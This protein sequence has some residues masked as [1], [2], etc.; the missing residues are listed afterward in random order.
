M[1]LSR[2]WY[3]VL[4]LVLGMA[5]YIVF[6]AVGQYNRRNGVAMTEE[7]ASDSQTVGWALQI[8]SRKRLDALLV[9]AVDKGV[10]DA[11]QGA[12]GKDAIPGKVK[13]DGRRALIAVLEK[14]AADFRP[15]ALF[16][17][18]HEGR[19]VS[20][21]G[22]DAANALPDFELGGYPVVFDAIHGYLR[23]DTWVLGG[24][25][26][27]VAARP[28]EFDA[29]Q[30]PLG[31]IVA[32]RLVDK[33]FTQDLS[34][35]TRANIAFYAGGQRVVSASLEGFDENQLALVDKDLPNLASDKAYGEGRSEVRF[36]SPDVGI[37]YARLF[38]DAW[39]LGG[40]FAVARDRI[41]IDG[42]QGF[43]NGADDKDKQSVNFVFIAAVVLGGILGGLLFS[44]LEHSL[45]L[46]EM[47]QQSLRL[48]KGEID[49]FQLP[50]FRGTY[51]A[52]AQ[53]VNLGIERVL[54]KGGSAL[55]KP[56]DLESILGPVP[57]QPA[58]SAFSFSAADSPPQPPPPPPRPLPSAPGFND[59]PGPAPHVPAAG[60]AG[61]VAAAAGLGG[62][63][64]GAVARPP[65]PKP[66]P[67]AHA[68]PASPVQGAPPATPGTPPTGPAA[69]GS[70]IPALP[71]IRRPVGSEP[72]VVLGQVGSGPLGGSSQAGPAGLAGSSPGGSG[73]LGGLPQAG[74]AGQQKQ[75]GFPPPP[76]A[77]PLKRT[78]SPTMVG[79]GE[80]PGA[81]SSPLSP[82]TSPH[83]FTPQ[84]PAVGSP[85]APGGG[86][87]AASPPAPSRPQVNAPPPGTTKVATPSPALPRPMQESGDQED[88]EATVVAPAPS[89][90]LAQTAGAAQAA[91]AKAPNETAEWMTVYDDFVRTKKQCGEPTEGL[92]FEKFQ[93]TLRKN[94]DALMQRHSCKRVRFSV[95]VK[96]GRASLKAT[97]LRD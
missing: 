69:D 96:D 87:A 22:Y 83:A 97:P 82:N 40:G 20:Q 6:L 21:V 26:Y 81:G 85:E 36:E 35:R 9:G 90:L 14:I 57:A 48:K 64:A 77:P 50:R 4:S 91:E 53:D 67:P 70:G 75:A 30:P 54:E 79:I 15:D 49:Y 55:R 59:A 5:A 41:T 17:V 68:A 73:G 76:K 63:L 92:T 45:P 65:P 62:A 46:R 84:R 33:K 66:A 16:A 61:L 43:L 89:D 2:I 29:T 27:R 71:V 28:V 60:G 74:P 44:F 56:A 12:N 38:G 34:K 51:R 25:L 94:R 52:I 23:D 39:E 8:D 72:G 78:G 88:D 93:A 11:L 58:M 1:I 24:K 3:I 13:E 47:H 31:A 42:W 18:D 37:M 80:R 10:E 32:L 19:V 7:L 86:P 95:Y